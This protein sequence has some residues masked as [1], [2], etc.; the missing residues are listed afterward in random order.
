LTGSAQE[1][2]PKYSRIKKVGVFV[3][4]DIISETS[5]K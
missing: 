5:D 2:M 3:L 1:E 4:G